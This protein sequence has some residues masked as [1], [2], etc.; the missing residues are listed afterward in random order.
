MNDFQTA[1]VIS[2]G[3]SAVMVATQYGRREYTWHKVIFPLL[4]VAG[5]G[6]GSTGK[7][8]TR[9]DAGFVVAWLVAVLLR[10]GFVW[11][12]DDVP[13]FRE[14]IG[15]F[16]NGGPQSRCRRQERPGWSPPPPGGRLD[17]NPSHRIPPYRVHPRR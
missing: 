4:S 16:M 7:L 8:Y 12:A 2:G 1:L 6:Y 10:V 9:C 15:T 13:G 14:Q 5:F 3:I 11:G 17:Q